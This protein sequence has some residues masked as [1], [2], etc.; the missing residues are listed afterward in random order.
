MPDQQ[1]EFDQVVADIQMPEMDGVELMQTIR[2]N[3]RWDHLPV[4][5]MTAHALQGDTDRLPELG[6]D[7]YV[8]KAIRTDF[9][10]GRHRTATGTGER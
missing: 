7:D 1:E 5:A 3:S 6:M 10:A 8:S 2:G 4:V 9:V